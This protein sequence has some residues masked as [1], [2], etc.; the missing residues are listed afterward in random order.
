MNFYI[1][2][3][4]FV[5]RVFCGYM[6]SA[7]LSQQCAVTAFGERF[8]FTVLK[9]GQSGMINWISHVTEEKF[10]KF[11]SKYYTVYIQTLRPH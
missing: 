11:F 5:Y 9:E 8:D 10:C 2:S 3:H 1:V 6:K 4:L 7:V